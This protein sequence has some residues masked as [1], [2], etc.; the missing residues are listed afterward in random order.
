MEIRQRFVNDIHSFKLI[1]CY[2]QNYLQNQR[3]DF[4]ST[5]II[6]LL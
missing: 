1:F 6:L 3:S 5:E 2:N 4:Y